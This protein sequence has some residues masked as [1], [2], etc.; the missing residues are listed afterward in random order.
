MAD[1]IILLIGIAL[2]M[3]LGTAVLVIAQDIIGIIRRKK[4]EKIGKALGRGFTDGVDGIDTY[5]FK[6]IANRV[7]T[8]LQ[9]L[10]EKEE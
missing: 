9:E 2:G 4:C 3:M 7:N 8:H 6:E 10:Q 1:C 5:Q